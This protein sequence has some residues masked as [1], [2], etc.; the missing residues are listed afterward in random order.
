MKLEEYD[1]CL[2]HSQS[3]QHKVDS[4]SD[5]FR[6]RGQDRLMGD[7]CSVYV[8]GKCDVTPIMMFG[9]NPGYSKINNPRE[10]DRELSQST[11]KYRGI[12]RALVEKLLRL[13]YDMK[14]AQGISA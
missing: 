2:N 4:L 3:N 13:S 11:L 14:N 7:N 10:A 5:L 12:D 8:V 9:I 1:L 6:L